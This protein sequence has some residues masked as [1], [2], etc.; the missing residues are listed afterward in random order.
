MGVWSWRTRAGLAAVL[1]LGVL[2]AAGILAAKNW[3]FTRSAVT[4][5]LQQHLSGTVVI[6]GFRQT[7]FP[8][9]AVAED[10]KVVFPLGT[11]Q[12]P[13]LSA[14]TMGIE[15]SWHGLISRSLARIHIDGL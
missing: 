13:P 10:I 9:G 15:G 11:S 3:P 14:R 8:P 2:A 12:T 6:G 1:A 7:W 5:E 4:R